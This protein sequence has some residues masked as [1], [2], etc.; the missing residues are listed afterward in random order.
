M[1]KQRIIII[2]FCIIGVISTFLPWMKAPIIGTINGTTGDG[3]IT[4]TLFLATIVFCLL[5]DKNKSPNGILLYATISAPL[6]AAMIGVYNILDV[7]SAIEDLEDNFLANLFGVEIT[8]KYGLFVLV[9]SGL[10]ASITAII[11]KTK[12][13]RVS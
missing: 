10:A 1:N 6:I 3:W 4:F 8:I 9:C 12:S 5:D 13:G 2:I 11:F 7:Q